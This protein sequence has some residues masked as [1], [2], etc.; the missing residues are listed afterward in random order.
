MTSVEP[1]FL[2]LN[3]QIIP[4]RAVS[5]QLIVLKQKIFNPVINCSTSRFFYLKAKRQKRRVATNGVDSLLGIINI[6]LFL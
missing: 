1:L 6:M 4:V 5:K 3:F 2:L